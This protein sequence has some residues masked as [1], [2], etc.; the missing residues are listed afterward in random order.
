MADRQTGR[1]LEGGATEGVLVEPRVVPRLDCGEI[2]PEGSGL[3]S[4]AAME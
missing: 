1:Q 2:R 4:S 3:A